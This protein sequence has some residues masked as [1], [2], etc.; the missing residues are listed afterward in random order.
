MSSV[1]IEVSKTKLILQ[2]IVIWVDNPRI[3]NNSDLQD[4][5]K[6]NNMYT[7]CTRYVCGKHIERH[8]IQQFLSEINIV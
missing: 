2:M 5:M 6:Y 4:L 8:Y 7:V 1:D 3:L